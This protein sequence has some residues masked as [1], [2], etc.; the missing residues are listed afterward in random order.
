MASLQPETPEHAEA[1]IG[2]EVH[3]ALCS[4]LGIHGV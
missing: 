1:Q 2:A 3:L 4:A